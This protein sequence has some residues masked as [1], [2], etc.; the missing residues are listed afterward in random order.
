M[1]DNKTTRVNTRGLYPEEEAMLK[2]LA[3]HYE[4]S[5]N[6]TLRM[7]VRSEYRRVIKPDPDGTAGLMA[8]LKKI[9]ND[10]K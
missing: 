9:V 1:P 3:T 2:E 4:R 10:N 5:L 6:D 7:L 8:G